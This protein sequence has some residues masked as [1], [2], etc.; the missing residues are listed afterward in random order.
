MVRMMTLHYPD[1]CQLRKQKRRSPQLI[2]A[3]VFARL[4]VQSTILLKSEPD[5]MT[6][7]AAFFSHANA[8]MYLPCVE[9]INE[10]S[11]FK[12]IHFVATNQ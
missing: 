2:S 6:V 1:L 4:I 11:D 7:Q 8:H 12:L 10:R 9:G 3:F 5:S